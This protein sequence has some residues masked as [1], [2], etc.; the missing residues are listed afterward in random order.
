MANKTPLSIAYP[1]QNSTKSSKPNIKTYEE[2]V[3]DKTFGDTKL[4]FQCK[5]EYRDISASAPKD[6]NS[7]VR[8]QVD[9][10][11]PNSSR[12]NRGQYGDHNLGSSPQDE[13]IED[14]SNTSF[15]EDDKR[16]NRLITPPPTSSAESS[17]SPPSSVEQHLAHNSFPPKESH[18]PFDSTLESKKE[19]VPPGPH[20]SKGHRPFMSS[21]TANTNLRPSTSLLIISIP[22][23]NAEARDNHAVSKHL[24]EELYRQTTQSSDADDERGDS[25][26]ENIFGDDEEDQDLSDR[27]DFMSAD[28]DDEGLHGQ[29]EAVSI[30]ARKRP[31]E[32]E[33]EEA[34]DEVEE[35]G[36]A[37]SLEDGEVKMNVQGGDG[38]LA[39]NRQRRN[40]IT[41]EDKHVLE[42]IKSVKRAKIVVEEALV[43]PEQEE[44]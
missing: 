6:R 19:N 4:D 9:A 8:S 18:A 15:E 25:D 21:S 31:L 14:H 23:P 34:G 33:D 10:L 30:T 37:N 38:G 41:H 27:N 43:V 42:D 1:K 20:L 28:K 22:L 44:L 16:I 11:N 2:N 29:L 5:D 7:H 12:K 13:I 39:A 17:N 36:T 26:L 40:A 35:R 32:E 3:R 24:G